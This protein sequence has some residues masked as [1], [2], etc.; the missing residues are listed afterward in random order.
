MISL[1]NM[2]QMKNELGRQQNILTVLFS[3]SCIRYE[4]ILLLTKELCMLIA[5]FRQIVPELN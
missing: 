2:N 3:V 5:N 4:E 1:S